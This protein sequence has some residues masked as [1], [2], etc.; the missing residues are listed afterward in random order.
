MLWGLIITQNIVY[1]SVKKKKGA[2]ALNRLKELRE[3]RHLNM[4]EMA[5][6]LNIPYTTYVNYEKGKREPDIGTLIALAD[7]FK[8]TVDCVLGRKYPFPLNIINTS[9]P[10]T[11]KY[12]KK[13]V[14]VEAFQY[15]G[16]LKASNGIYYVPDWAVKAFSEGIMYYDDLEGEPAE[17]FIKTLEGVHHVSVG[18]FVIK[19]IKGELYPC[20]P[21]IFKETYEP[22]E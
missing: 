10:Q 16:D 1:G 13:P 20:K 12:R 4:R 5:K 18:D 8:V 15:D 22:V 2:Q 9:I 11:K 7:Y 21:D 17:L 6:E 14:V 3:S 19:G